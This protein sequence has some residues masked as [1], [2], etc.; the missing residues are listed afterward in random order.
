MI[1]HMNER[2]YFYLGED[3]KKPLGPVSMQ[4]LSAMLQYGQLTPE[5]EVAVRGGEKWISLRDLLATQT[6]TTLPPVPAAPC[7]L[8]PVPQ[9]YPQYAP[10]YPGMQ[11]YMNIPETAGPCPNCNREIALNGKPELP[12]RCPNCDYLLRPADPTSL[13]QSFLVAMKKS[14]TFKGRATRMEYWS[15]YLFGSLISMAMSLPLSVAEVVSLSPEQL[16]ADDESYMFTEEYWSSMAGVCQ[17]LQLAVSLIFTIPQISAGVRRLHD[18]GKSGW[19]LG[20]LWL[21]IMAIIG[22][23]ILTLAQV[24]NPHGAMLNISII[25]ILGCSL[26]TLVLSIIILVFLCRDSELGRNR[27]GASPKYPYL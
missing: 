12:E 8:P 10:Y 19:W 6:Q 13:W 18:I 5:T 4:E 24:E 23:L 16:L 27:Y 22:F 21:S 2:K 26:G 7:N 17:I 20:S 25:G 11:P 15:L 1:A 9:F 3:R 14:F